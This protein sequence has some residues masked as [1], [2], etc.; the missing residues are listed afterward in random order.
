MSDQGH[1]LFLCTGNSCRSQIA[2]AL[3]NH[4]EAE[5]WRAS[6]AGTL[7]DGEVH[8]LALAVLS[9]IGVKT[10]GLRSKSVDEIAGVKAMIVSISIAGSFS[11]RRSSSRN[12]STSWSGSTRQSISALAL[13]GTTLILS[14]ASSRVSEQ[15]FLVI[16]A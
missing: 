14:L 5:R 11:A 8:P 3:V 4:F 1:V 6:S 9:E 15:V 12:A 13:G 10:R 2:E 16:A 7:P